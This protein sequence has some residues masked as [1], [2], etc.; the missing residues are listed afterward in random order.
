MP[1]VFDKNGRELHKGSRAMD[2][3]NGQIA[4]ITGFDFGRRKIQLRWETP[5]LTRLIMAPLLS[6]RIPAV[7][8]ISAASSE[9]FVADDLLLI[10]SP[11]SNQQTTEEAASAAPDKELHS[12]RSD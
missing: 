2:V 10:D 7:R 8:N 6:I 3:T 4:V 1:K 12:V 9:E 5:S 11:S